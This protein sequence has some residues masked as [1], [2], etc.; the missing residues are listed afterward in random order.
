MTIFKAYCWNSNTGRDFTIKKPNWNIVQ[1]C[2]LKSIETIALLPQHIYLLDGTT[3]S[4]TSKRWQ[5][6]KCPDDWN[7]PFSYGS[8]ITK[9]QGEN[10]ISGIAFCTDYERKQYPNLYPNFVTPNLKQG[11]KYGLSGT[12]Y[13]SSVNVLEV[14]LKLLYGTKNELVATYQVQPNQYLDIKEIYTLPS[15]E[16]VE[17]F[18]IAFEVAQTSDF[19]QFEVYLPKI[20]QGGEVTPFVE[21]R[22]EFESYKKTNTDDGTPP[23]TG[24][25]E[26]TAPQST[27]YKDYI[28]AGSK[29]D[30]ELFYLEERGICKQE[31]VWCYSRPL[32]QRVLIGIDSDTYDTEAGRTL[33]FRV[34]NGNK[35]IFDLTGNVIYPDQ[36]TNTRQTFDSDTKAW[37]DNQEPLYVTDANTAID[38]TFG[39]MASNILEGDY[40]QQA[41]K[42][43]KVDELIRSAMLNIGYNMGSYW[44]DW[45]FNSYVT[46]MRAT[47][48]MNNCRVSEKTKYSSMNEWTGSVAFPT[49]VVLAPYKPKLSETDTKKF[50]GVSSAT[51]I[52]ATG[53]LRTERSIEDWFR[54]YENSRT[55]P[56]PTQIL[57]INYNTKKAWLFQQQ[58]NGTWNKSGEINTPFDDPA[59]ASTW[60]II[61]KNGELKGNVIMTDKNYDD[62][63]TNARPITL[64]VEE[65]F[66]VIKYN[67]VKFNPQMYATAYNTKLFWWGQKA[68]V[69]NLTYGE[70]GVRSVDFMTGLCTIER[71]YK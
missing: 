47:P 34:I 59:L 4:E 17:K 31:A 62:F 16:T 65:L 14:S 45:D 15:T 68:N 53:L 58:S 56:V 26:G 24:T 49:G 61:P 19:V 48:G 8:I 44:A 55:R 28:W 57:F 66:P 69:S 35:G 21:D 37:V 64:G 60:G 22:D 36:F 50:K 41:D 12:L 9:P 63:P 6:K 40:Y 18:G 71:V 10:K 51:G 7:R 46:E 43:Y 23:F 5:R 20:E 30:K 52:W 54:E 1:R 33:K 29:T 2:S 42:R 13:N 39:E 70:C 11:Q 38:C 3:G 27:N 25:Y 67:E 32:G